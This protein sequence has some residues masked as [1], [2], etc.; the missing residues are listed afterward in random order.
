MRWFHHLPEDM[1]EM[2][3]EEFA[4]ENLGENRRSRKRRPQAHQPHHKGS[5]HLRKENFKNIKDYDQ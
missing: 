4:S 5:P 3:K 2:E 1:P